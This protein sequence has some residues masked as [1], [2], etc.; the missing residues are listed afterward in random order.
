MIDADV[1]AVDVRAFRAVGHKVSSRAWKV[2]KW[3]RVHIIK[4]ECR[5]WSAARTIAKIVSW[6]R[7]SIRR[8]DGSDWRGYGSTSGQREQ[9]ARS[10]SEQLA[11]IADAHSRR[12]HRHRLRI[13]SAAEDRRTV[14]L[15]VQ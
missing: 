11:E 6:N 14:S 9:A 7:C 15:S 4:R 1:V 12:W 5:E 3:K 8:E 13:A 2:W 10:G